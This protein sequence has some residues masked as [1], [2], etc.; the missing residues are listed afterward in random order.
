[1]FSRS[2]ATR[3]ANTAIIAILPA[4]AAC[5]DAPTSTPAARGVGDAALAVRDC[6][7]RCDN[8]I[9]FDAGAQP[10]DGVRHIYTVMPDGSGLT[11]LTSGQHADQAPSWSANYR[12]IVFTSNRHGGVH[13]VYSMNA[14]GEGV[15]RLTNSAGLLES[16][17]VL[18]PD[19]TKIVF[20][21]QWVTGKFGIVLMNSDGTN[22]G[23]F[24]LAGNNL[25]PTFSPDS[26]K[27]LFSS[28]LHSTSGS[29]L[30]RDIYVMNLD[31]SN[32][33]RLTFDAAYD[34]N[35]VWAPDG[36]KIFFES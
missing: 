24:P 8:P 23:G 1:M 34:V 33:K 5:G 16:S 9:V 13:N 27:I 12:R 29:Y 17:P 15:T 30:D 10:G 36:S 32:R 20:V 18:S 11:Q 19:G 14:R 28:D 21:R 6:T 35:P 7:A 31:G 26:K 4:F 3:A 25:H 2:G 22:Q